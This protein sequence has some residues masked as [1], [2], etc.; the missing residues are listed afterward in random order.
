M[1]FNGRAVRRAGGLLAG[2]VVVLLHGCEQPSA[3]L[4]EPPPNIPPVTSQGRRLTFGPD[5]DVARGFT[6]DGRV[7]FST[8]NL[9][10]FG[11]ERIVASIAPE[12]GP[13]REEAGIYRLAFR[14][15]VGAMAFASGRRVMAV[16]T[17]SVPRE[18]YACPDT[19]PAPPPAV[20]VTLFELGPTDGTALANLPARAVPVEAV[21]GEG[22]IDV[23]GAG[24]TVSFR[25]RVTPAQ[26]EIAGRGTN[27]FGPVPLP[28]GSL[29]FS[30]GERLWHGRAG[31]TTAL[32]LLGAGAFP[33]LDSSGTM[34]A[35]ARPVAIDSTVVV[36]RI[37]VFGGDCVQE[38]VEVTSGG[39]EVVLR[40]LR[41]GAERVLAEGIEPV[42][43]P[44]AP[45][46]LY[47]APS[48]LRWVSLDGVDLGSFDGTAGAFAPA[49]SPDGALGA[50]SWSGPDGVDVYFREIER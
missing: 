14:Q 6:L 48:G 15:E 17:P 25:V 42:L 8:R 30:D 1:R 34:L 40:D 27:P 9:V 49:I 29:I 50:Y 41:S 19:A 31:D 32:A 5:T 16:W 43:D 21:E 38:H 3:I 20:H 24:Q 33:S 45:R 44:V 12:G 22:K 4:V 2:A 18:F 23:G 36:Y 13:A 39:W 28:D 47:R 7:V 11:P 37:P 26:R 10:P 46:L 35:F